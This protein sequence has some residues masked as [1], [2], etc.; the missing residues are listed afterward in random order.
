MDI[1]PLAESDDR[2]Q[3]RIGQADLDRFFYEDALA[4]AAERI[5]RT[6]VAVNDA[7]VVGFVTVC[8][9]VVRANAHLP[10]TRFR[11]PFP[12]LLIARLGTDV[13][14]RGKGIGDALVRQALR[15]A[16]E[17]AEAVACALV[18]VDSK[19]E[20]VWFWRDKWQFTLL[21]P[22][23]THGIARYYLRTDFL[24]ELRPRS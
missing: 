1:R 24:A 4:A 18:V 22:E 8:P 2:A 3:V 6:Y 15:L 9:A 14:H 16:S 19:P 13:E 20:S 7:R 21:K 23:D 10:N 12:C 11:Y 17:M 5:S